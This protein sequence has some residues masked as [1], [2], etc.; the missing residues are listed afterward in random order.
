MLALANLPDLV[1]ALTETIFDHI[2][3]LDALDRAIGDGDHGTNLERG[4]RA[5]LGG[6]PELAGEPYGA[7]LAGIGRLLAMSVGGASGALYGTLFM[8]F[9]R[10]LPTPC[11]RAGLAAA[12]GAGVAAV[13]AR[14]RSAPGEIGRASCRERV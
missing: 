3:E 11:D 6:W 12:F 14:G 1:A 5:V 8:A 2:E 10:A 4:A 9:G 13:A 7:A